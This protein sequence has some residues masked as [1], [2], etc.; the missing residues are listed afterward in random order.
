MVISDPKA[1]QKKK[2]SQRGS[3]VDQNH[4]GSLLYIPHCCRKL[5]EP[6]TCLRRMPEQKCQVMVA[7][8]TQRGTKTH[9]NLQLQFS[10]LKGDPR[11]F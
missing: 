6:D 4:Y 8:V 5:T 10:P 11:D 2:N 9:V 1:L 7:A 3:S